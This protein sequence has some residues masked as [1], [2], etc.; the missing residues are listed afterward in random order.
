VAPVVAVEP[1]SLERG[2][3]QRL[4]NLEG[5]AELRVSRIRATEPAALG[6]LAQLQPQRV[7][8]S[9]H[10]VPVEL[11]DGCRENSVP[12][13]Q[14]RRTSNSAVRDLQAQ[15]NRADD[16]REAENAPYRWGGPGAHFRST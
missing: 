3:Q 6:G 2:D 8:W 14:V 5:L 4:R 12:T 15:V 10:G 13:M 16:Y 1:A 7:L 9:L 11:G